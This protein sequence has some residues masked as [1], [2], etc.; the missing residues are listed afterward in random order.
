[1]LLHE[2]DHIELGAQSNVPITSNMAGAAEE[3]Q[4]GPLLLRGSV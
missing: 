1:M 4:T 3:K 2:I